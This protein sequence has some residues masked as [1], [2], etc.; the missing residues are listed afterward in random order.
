MLLELFSALALSSIQENPCIEMNDEKVI[1][2]K[3]IQLIKDCWHGQIHKKHNI[4]S[5]QDGQDFITL[6]PW[7]PCDYH[8][9][10]FRKEIAQPI[11]RPYQGIKPNFTWELES[12]DKYPQL[13]YDWEFKVSDKEHLLDNWADGIFLA[14]WHAYRHPLEKDTKGASPVIGIYYASDN[15]SKG[16]G[17][18]YLTAKIMRSY[19]LCLKSDRPQSLAFCYKEVARTRISENVYNKINI[20]I[21]WDQGF[22]QTGSTEITIN[23]RPLDEILDKKIPVNNNVFS[24][25]NK[26]NRHPNYFKLGLYVINKQKKKKYRKDMRTKKEEPFFCGQEGEIQYSVKNFKVKS[27]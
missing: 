22:T 18:L 20:K 1:T 23:G 16:E 21:K 3:N 8:A 19:D 7:K 14:Q 6:F 27:L 12:E 2:T 5:K 24:F 11:N 9:R 25:P 4:I 15:S 17:W 10:G 13:E 26:Q